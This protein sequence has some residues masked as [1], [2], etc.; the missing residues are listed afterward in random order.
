MEWNTLFRPKAQVI[1]RW[2][3]GEKKSEKKTS[4]KIIEAAAYC[5]LSPSHQWVGY[6]GSKI[7]GTDFLLD[8]AI[9]GLY[10]WEQYIYWLDNPAAIAPEP[11]G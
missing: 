1:Q 9:L 11:L 6:W 8:L 4:S 3:E 5:L 7:S 2:Q 10:S